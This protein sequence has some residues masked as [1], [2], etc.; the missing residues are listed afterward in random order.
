MTAGSSFCI[1]ADNPEGK[2]NIVN[3]TTGIYW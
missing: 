3:K 1:G 2:Q